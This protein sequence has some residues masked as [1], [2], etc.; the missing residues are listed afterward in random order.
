MVYSGLEAFIDI[1]T[2]TLVV[3]GV[4]RL[5]IKNKKIIFVAAY[6]INILISIFFACFVRENI[7]TNKCFHFYTFN[8]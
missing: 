4:F 1:F 8:N 7:P 3:Y 6:L 2:K 5:E